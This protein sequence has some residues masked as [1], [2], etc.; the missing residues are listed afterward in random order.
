IDLSNSIG[1]WSQINKIYQYEISAF[2]VNEQSEGNREIALYVTNI[3]AP[4]GTVIYFDIYEDDGVGTN[5]DI[6]VDLTTLNGTVDSTG[7]VYF[8]WNITDLDLNNSRDSLV[9]DTP[10]DLPEVLTPSV[11]T[12]YEVYFG[13]RYDSTEYKIFTNKILNL[14]DARGEIVVCET[15][16]YCSDYSGAGSCN[17]DT[18]NVADASSPSQYVDCSAEDI[19]CSCSW[20]ATTSVCGPSWFSG[21]LNETTNEFFEVGNCLYSEDL[22][23]DDC[24]DGYLD[25]S[26][27]AIW[28]W[29]TGNEVTKTDPNNAEGDCVPGSDTI[30]CPAQVQLSGFNWINVILIIIILIVIYYFI[31]KRGNNKVV[32]KKKK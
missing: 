25:Y 6:R 15:K 2:E 4:E 8:K 7:R 12:H 22:S 9:G 23:S 20:N 32:K 27:G 3:T 21:F 24:S 17:A 19:S 31:T 5:D 1:N 30:A 16:N 29:A 11:D 26:W 18:C 13:I 28:N 10:K 14:T